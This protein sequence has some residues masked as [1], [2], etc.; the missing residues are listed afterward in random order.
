VK[1][2]FYSFI[3]LCGAITAHAAIAANHY[4]RG[5]ATGTGNGNDWTNAYTS[6]PANLVR[7]DTYFIADGVYGSYVFNDPQSGSSS[8]ILKKPTQAD[9][10]TDVGWNAA[11]G[12]GEALFTGPSP[13]WTFSSGFYTID[14]AVGT[15]KA[16]VPYGFRVM[17]TTSRCVNEFSSAVMFASRSNITNLTLRHIDLGWNNGSSSCPGAV[18]A[19][20]FT[21]DAS[22]DYITLENSYLHH[23]PGFAL[24]IGPYNPNPGGVL[25]NH[26]TIRN[27]HF[28][29]IGGGG[30]DSAHWELM[31]L[32]NVDNSDI[33]NNVIEDVVGEAGQTGWVMIAKANNLNI[34]GNVFFCTVANCV[35]GGNG[36]IATWSL[37]SYRNDSVRIYNNTFANLVG[38]FNN[39]GIRFSHNSVADTNI[40]LRNNLY[41]SARFSW[42]GVTSQSHEAC[43]CGQPCSGTNQQSGITAATFVN[44]S[45]RDFRL[46]TPTAAGDSTLGQQFSRD[47]NGTLRGADGIWDR[48]AYEYGVSTLPAPGNLRVTPLAN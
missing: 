39:F 48:G 45:G 46:A 18:P 15:G 44:Y 7:G 2:L 25:E 3:M 6:L 19:L 21:Q 36:V 17:P 33:Y 42:S 14:G 20:F 24:Y 13:V 32:M 35:V 47:V 16:A 27:N 5:G 38:V 30:S 10:G 41:C 37:D 29:M 34:Y 23:A 1:S 40:I 31:W 9:H 4:V 11:Y 28:H 8:I 12:D 22:S 43:G 26:Y